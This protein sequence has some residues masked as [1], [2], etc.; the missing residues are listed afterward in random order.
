MNTTDNRGV[1]TPIHTACE[2]AESALADAN[3][4]LAC[5]PVIMDASEGVS[6]RDIAYWGVSEGMVR[7]YKVLATIIALGDDEGAQC[8]LFTARKVVNA[9]F[10]VKGITTEMM[11]EVIAESDTVS[12]AV[13][14]LQALALAP[15]MTEVDEDETDGDGNGDEE[16]TPDPKD[17]IAK[18]VTNWLTA[19]QGSLRKVVEAQGNGFVLTDEQVVALATLTDLVAQ[20]NAN[21]NAQKTVVSV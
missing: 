1:L 8:D 20:I 4:V 14:G 16:P 7:R 5:L 9:T 17:D 21:A 19:G 6:N 18:K 13:A 15:V 3:E 11:N 2:I 12:Q 10:K